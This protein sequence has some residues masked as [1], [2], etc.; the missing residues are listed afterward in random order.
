ML[1]APRLA[2]VQVNGTS[3]ALFTTG[4]WRGSNYALWLLVTQAETGLQTMGQIPTI[5]VA[6]NML[7]ELW[8]TLMLV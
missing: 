6:G 7:E 8:C 3:N 5:S 2:C 4:V 1:A